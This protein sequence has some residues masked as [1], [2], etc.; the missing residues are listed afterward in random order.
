MSADAL[1]N[2][3]DALENEFFARQNAKS[4]EAFRAKVAAQETRDA[5][6]AALGISEA[7]VLDGLVRVGIT[8]E[9]L[10][11]L[12]M[13][14]LVAVAWADG[15][16]DAAEREAIERA[17]DEANVTDDH[18]TL[19]AGWL[20]APPEAGL[21]EAWK[22]YAESLAQE[23]DAAACDALRSRILGGARQVAESAGGF[24][25]VGNKISASEASVLAELEAC[26]AH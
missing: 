1:K 17:A 15:K 21:L 10:A 12:A 4:L 24:L 23:M 19:L 25:G 6:A 20:S 9:T 18:R 22:Q 7:S 14:P 3:K 16:L 13:I 26:F 2:R 8:A 5:L 11:A